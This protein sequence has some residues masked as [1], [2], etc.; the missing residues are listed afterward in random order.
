MNSKYRPDQVCNSLGLP[1]HVE[2][3]NGFCYRDFHSLLHSYATALAKSGA[4]LR[5]VQILC[6]HSSP[7]VT[8]RYVHADFS[9]LHEAANRLSS[10]VEVEGDDSKPCSKHAQRNEGLGGM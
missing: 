2:T 8:A 10:S 4:D 6:G 5:T 1:Y 3:E 9:Q 7:S